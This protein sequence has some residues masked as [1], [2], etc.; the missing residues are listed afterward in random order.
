MLRPTDFWRSLLPLA[1]VAGLSCGLGQVATAQVAPQY[2]VPYPNRYQLP[3]AAVQPRA[4]AHAP[5]VPDPSG[6]ELLAPAQSPPTSP[7]LQPIPNPQSL[8]I[9][10]VPAATFCQGEYIGPHRDRH[11]PVYRLRVDDQLAFVYRIDRVESKAPYELN[12][13]DQITIESLTDE[14]LSRTLIVQPDGKITV[15]LIGQV[16]AAGRTITELRD[17]LEER[18]KKF[19]KV[20]SITITPVTVNTKL[21][22]LRS[23]VDTRYGQGGQS[24]PATVS[25]DGTVQRPAIGNV[26]AQGLTLS[27]LRREVNARYADIVIGMEI[28]PVLVQRAPRFVYVL[29]EV[30]QPGQITLSGPTTVMQAISMAQGWNVGAGLQRIVIFRRT[31][32][33]RLIATQLDLRQ[34]LWGRQPC[35]GGEIWLRD[36]DVVLVPKSDLLLT[37]DTINLLFTRGLYGIFPFGNAPSFSRASTL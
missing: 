13:G 27:E 9:R 14:S 36:S 28:T 29:G 12:V 26:Q 7:R 11:L 35:P 16:Q 4:V 23:P 20:P 8:Q 22:D 37:T 33:W 24:G 31:E 18:Y 21:E 17:D 30:R 2:R 32:D 5:T 1:V 19:N 6:P 25:P 3:P 15:R 10:E 34:A